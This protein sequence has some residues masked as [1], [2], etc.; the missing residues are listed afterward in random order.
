MN[1]GE[2][3]TRNNRNGR[4]RAWLQLF[5]LPNLFTVPGDP[6]VGACIAAQ[7][8]NIPWDTVGVVLLIALL[9][10]ASGLAWNDYFDLPRDRRRRKDRPL[11][12]G[13][14]HP[15]AALWAGNM[16]A[17]VGLTLCARMG[18]ATFWIGLL[19]VACVFGYNRHLKSIPVIGVLVMGACRGLSVLLG[20]AAV[21]VVHPF[22]AS[23]WIAAL[24]MLLYV[25]AVTQIARREAEP[26]Q[27]GGEIWMPAIA[28]LLG[29]LFYVPFLP[30]LSGARA[31]F[32]VLYT[33]AM[34]VAWV[35]A[36]TMRGFALSPNL[37]LAL[38]R[39]DHILF[40][41]PAWIGRLIA[42]IIFIQAAFIFGAGCG[43]IGL[44]T[45]GAVL[46][47]GVLN[48]MLVRWFYAS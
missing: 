33:A 31:G 21:P 29:V 47:G 10:Y 35:F 25:A 19:L 12:S 45:A 18:G 42:N 30:G 48:R 7:S 3:D 44:Y 2:T 39:K 13:R 6:L 8:L 26:H 4:F 14:I 20:A 16:L 43:E 22:P 41:M 23:V 32:L 17:L 27:P 11:P 1:T 15:R 28:L 9:L 36:F 5:R 46:A 38:E 24:I 37:P 34:T 40:V